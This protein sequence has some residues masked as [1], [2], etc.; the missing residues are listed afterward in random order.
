MEESSALLGKTKMLILVYF[1]LAESTQCWV[2]VTTRQGLVK[3]PSMNSAE[4]LPQVASAC[5]SSTEGMSVGSKS[6]LYIN[7]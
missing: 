6:I 3:L 4:E 1:N 2:A 5:A 7:P